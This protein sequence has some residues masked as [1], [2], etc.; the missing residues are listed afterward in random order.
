MADIE[1]VL[2]PPDVIDLTIQEGNPI[3][4]NMRTPTPIQL[5]VNTG[6]ATYNIQ[7]GLNVVGTANEI[8]VT[9]VDQTAT[10]GIANPCTISNVSIDQSFSVDCGSTYNDDVLMNAS[11]E[12]AQTTTLN[13]T[14]INGALNVS[15]TAD[16]NDTVTVVAGQSLIADVGGD[17]Q[18][19]LPNPT[20]HRIKNIDIHNSPDDLD[21]FQ[22]KTSN[23]KYHWVTF[24]EAG[25][26]AAS[27]TH[28]GA[29]ITSGTVAFARLPTGTTS[30]TVAIGNH[31]HS[32]ADITSGTVGFSYLPTGTTS[33]TVAIGNH[34]HTIEDI[35]DF[36]ESK[37]YVES[38][39]N[40]AGEFSSISV[41][42]GSNLF[43]STSLPVDG[44]FGILDSQTSTAGM[45]AGIGSGNG[46]DSISFGSYKVQ[47]TGIIYL[48]VISDTTNTYIIECGFSDNRSGTATDGAYITYSNGIN[49]GKWQGVVYNAGTATTFDLGIT[50]LA[51]TWYKL[52]VVVN[53]NRSVEFYVDGVLKA[54]ASAGTAPDGS[55]SV[56]R[57][58]GFGYTI[59]KTL[60]SVT[61][62]LYVDYLNLQID[63]SR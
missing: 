17:L 25:V 24:A 23:N 5:S 38:D 4:L 16:F 18:G 40:A 60:G 51:N 45:V 42:S 59:R 50:V 15:S 62:S 13:V 1:L 56:T 58:C 37:I 28:S 20:V 47:T 44:H 49:S 6:S 22:Y 43:T 14:N 61:R 32:G 7:G 41:S 11:L 33:S 46:T 36:K 9:I 35:T 39:C 30:S 12:V 52:K 31:T 8:D 29:D 2:Q 57:R 10:V 63:T 26:A 48:P 3:T 55:G 27:H 19:T 53:V 21:L 54:T 34:T